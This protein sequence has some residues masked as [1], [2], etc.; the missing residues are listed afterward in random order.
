MDPIEHAREAQFPRLPTGKKSPGPER[1]QF[2]HGVEELLSKSVVPSGQANHAHGPADPLGK[3]MPRFNVFE[4]H[5]THAV[6]AEKSWSVQ[7]AEQFVQVPKAPG[8]EEVPAGH[9]THGVAG[10]ES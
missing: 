1:E 3:Y 10:L 4:L 6:E 9:G 7:P 8:P 5:W 2:W